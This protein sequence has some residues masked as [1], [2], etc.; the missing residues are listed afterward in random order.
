MQNLQK[1][2]GEKKKKRQVAIK[3]EARVLPDEQEGKNISISQ[4]QTQLEN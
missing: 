1:I 3:E 2:R 4:L